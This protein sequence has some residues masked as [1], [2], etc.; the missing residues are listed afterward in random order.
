MF[1]DQDN[2]NINIKIQIQIQIQ[3][4]V[5]LPRFLSTFS[6]DKPSIEPSI[7]NEC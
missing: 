7:V 2:I 6:F 1:I 5:W 4:K 3:T